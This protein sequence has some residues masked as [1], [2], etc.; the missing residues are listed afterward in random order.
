MCKRGSVV[1]TG[2]WPAATGASGQSLLRGHPDVGTLKTDAEDV[3]VGENGRGR[4]VLRRAGGRL[5]G[6]PAL[7][8]AIVAA[9]APPCAAIG[10]VEPVIGSD[11]ADAFVNGHEVDEVADQLPLRGVVIHEVQPLASVIGAEPEIGCD[12]EFQYQEVVLFLLS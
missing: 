2:S 7:A 10:G 5:V 9:V 6:D 12:P 8:G 3:V 11:P 1:R 4:E